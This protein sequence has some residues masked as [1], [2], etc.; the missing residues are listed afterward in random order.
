MSTHPVH[1]PVQLGVERAPRLER[2]HVVIRLVLL[3]AIGLIGLSSVYWMLY[4]GLPA[5]VALLVLRRGR[6]AYLVEEGPRLV[7]VLRWLTG[8]HAYLWLLTDVL[9]SLDPGGQAPVDF[10]VE[11]GGVPTG[12]SVLLRIVYS[13]PALL[14]AAVLSVAGSLLWL[15]GAGFVLVQERMPAPI[16]DFLAMALRYHARLIA[17][18]LSLVERY[19]SLD[20]EQELEHHHGHDQRHDD[21]GIAQ[22]TGSPAAR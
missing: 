14:L 2:I 1:H 11:L 7:R 15:V 18:H 19:P 16:A 9:P 6:Q 8:A 3:V 4:L 17:Y 21:D 12:R 10:Q 22:V 20:H 5:V 13:L